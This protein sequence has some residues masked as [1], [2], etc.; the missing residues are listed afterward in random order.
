MT[1]DFDLCPICGIFPRVWNFDRCEGCRRA[2]DARAPWL[3]AAQA[4]VMEH[5]D[6]GLLHRLAH[7]LGLALDRKPVSW[8]LR[9]RR[10]L[11]MCIAFQCQTCGLLDVRFVGPWRE[12]AIQ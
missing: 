7:L 8:T 6:A 3:H 1:F 9:R 2:W 5:R 12:Q 11:V 10:G 4:Q